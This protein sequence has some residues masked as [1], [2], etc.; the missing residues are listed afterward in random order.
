M[1]RTQLKYIAITAMLLDHIGM[2]FG[3]F[4]MHTTWGPA[5]YF[6][7][8]FL[9]RLTAPIMCF[10]LTEGY[11]FTHSR[12]NYALRLLIFA[13]V[14]Q[15]PYALA[16]NNSLLTPDFN[17]LFMLLISLAVLRVLES[18]IKEY[19]KFFLVFVLMGFTCYCDWGFFGP[20]MVICF[21]VFREKPLKLVLFYCLI[22]LGI[23]VLSCFFLPVKGIE[24]YSELW[25]LGLFLFIPVLYVY[26]GEGGQKNAFNKWFFYIFYP[27]HLL[28]LWAIKLA[29]Q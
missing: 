17:M 27:L 16:H 14:S 12:K 1:N 9:G 15:V 26:N 28:I 19:F 6:V 23:N 13:I 18:G 2:L 22:V 4:F 3:G 24:W 10:F 7:L 5:L 20:L 11:I 25:Q 21:Y 29:I 8:R